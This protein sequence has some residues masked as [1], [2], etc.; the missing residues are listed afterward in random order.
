MARSLKALFKTDKALE[1]KGVE[2][3]Y[4]FAVITVARAGGSNTAYK[5]ALIDVL[6]PFRQALQS[7][8]IEEA[9]LQPK[10]IKLFSEMIVLNWQTRKADGTLVQGLEG[11]DG[12]EGELLPFTPENV[13]KYLTEVP[14][15]YEA[16]EKE[17]TGRKLFLQD[18]EAAAGN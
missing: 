6:Q 8:L 3:D 13:C 7:G 9:V 2:I 14:E 4:N 15:L 18:L 1:R 10:F 11:N 12:T 17:A 5:K 16:L